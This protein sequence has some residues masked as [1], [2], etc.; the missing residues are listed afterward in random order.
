[1]KKQMHPTEERELVLHL[2]QQQRQQQ[3]IRLCALQSFAT[4]PCPS[5]SYHPLP[6]LSRVPNAFHH[7]FT[8][9]FWKPAYPI[10]P[11]L[12]AAERTLR[13]RK[14]ERERRKSRSR[15]LPTAWP[16]NLAAHDDINVCE[17]TPLRRP[18]LLLAH[19]PSPTTTTLLRPLPPAHP[20]VCITKRQL[21]HQRLP[22]LLRHLGHRRRRSR[23]TPATG[24]VLSGESHHTGLGFLHTRLQPDLLRVGAR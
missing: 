2:Q 16:A 22:S 24:L 9:T 12:S 20:S 6:S 5:L 13:S 10:N 17:C 11:R 8:T 18:L 7:Y 14:A 21:Q 4:L 3:D 23:F 1:M 19:L 15:S